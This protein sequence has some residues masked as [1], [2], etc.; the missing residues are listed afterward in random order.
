M[1][2][3]DQLELIKNW[4]LKPDFIINLK[5]GQLGKCLYQKSGE[6]C[7]CLVFVLYGSQTN[8]NQ[9]TESFYKADM[10]FDLVAAMF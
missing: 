7:W 1:A 10:L 6:F 4:K 2:V 9:H 3:K 8:G 5:V